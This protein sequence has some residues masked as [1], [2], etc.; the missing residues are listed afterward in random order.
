[1]IQF[2]LV[3]GLIVVPAFFY[4]RQSEIVANC[5]VDTGSAGTAVDIDLVKLDYSRPSRIV[6]I[7]GIGGNQEV[8]I[9]RIDNVDFC[10]RQV[11]NFEVQFG[12]IASKFG[13]NAIIGSDLLNALGVCI[14]YERKEILLSSKKR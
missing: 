6:E 3:D 1:M 4:Y 9:Q 8:V 12:D 11:K 2:E 10:K 7:A 5:L 14:D 13:F